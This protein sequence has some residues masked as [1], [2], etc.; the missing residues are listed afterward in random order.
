MEVRQVDGSLYKKSSLVS[1]RHGLQRKFKE[2]RMELD[3]ISDNEFVESNNTMFKAQCI[4][5]KKNGLGKTDHKPSI[6]TED[7]AKLYESDTLH[8]LFINHC[9][10]NAKFFLNYFFSYVDV[11]EKI[12]EN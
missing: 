6:S 11:A 12:C 2:W 3:I 4:Q 5:M 10:C 8:S 9:L 7:V 1:I